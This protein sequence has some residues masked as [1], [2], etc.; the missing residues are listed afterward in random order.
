MNLNLILGFC[1]QL[2]ASIFLLSSLLC[3]PNKGFKEFH[4]HHP[5]A[6]QANYPIR[7]CRFR[8]CFHPVVSQALHPFRLVIA[9][10]RDGHR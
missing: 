10:N 8:D 2:L 4:Q 3:L 6:R 1:A 7:H 9:V 5:F